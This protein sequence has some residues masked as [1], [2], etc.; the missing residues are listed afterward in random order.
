[1]KDLK[2]I[3][4]THDRKDLMEDNVCSVTNN[5]IITVFFLSQL[6]AGSP[7]IN[8]VSVNLVEL[9]TFFSSYLRLKEI[10]MNSFLFLYLEN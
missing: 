7:S 8:N 2:S 3:N 6:S 10:K 9:F 4:H 1:M 5:K